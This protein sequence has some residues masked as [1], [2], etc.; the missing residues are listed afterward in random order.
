MS[1]IF[2]VLN[3]G[4]DSWDSNMPGYQGDYGGA[5]NW[6]RRNKA[7]DENDAIDARL[8]QQHAQKQEYEKSGKFWLK[9]K[10]SQR[11]LPSGPFTGKQAANTAALELLKQQPELKGNLVITAYGP[12]ETQG[13]AEA[14]ANYDA[15]WDEKVKRVGQ[16]AK[17]GP[18]KTV[19][20]PVKR[21][22][23][24]VPVNTPKKEE[25]VTE[26]SP[27]TTFNLLKGLKTW[28]VVLFNNYYAGKY[29]DYRGRYYY[30]LASSPEEARQV[31]LDNSDAILQDILSMKSQNGKKI[32][33]RGTA[34][35]ITDK[36]IGEI[37]DGT[38]AGRMSTMGFKR[39][40][41][42]QGPMMVKLSDGAVVDIQGQ[43]LGVAEG[44]QFK[45]G[46]PFDVDHMP[47]AV[48][49]NSDKATDIVKTKN[50]DKWDDEVDRIND[51]VFDDMSDFRT[52]SKGETVTGNSA[53][54]AKWDNATQTGWINR[55]GQPLKPWPV[56]EQ[57]VA[58]A[59]RNPH[60]SALGKA[61]YR[62]LSKEKKAS[63]QQVQRN[64][65]RWAQRQAEK[66]KEVDEGYDKWGWHTSLTNGKFMPTK[67]GNKMYVYLHDLDNESPR[68]GPQLVTVNKPTV[69]KR[70]AQQ[71]GGE[72]VKTD[73]NTYR[74]VKPAEQDV[75]EDWQKVNKKDK[76]D[77][78]SRKAVKAYRRENPGSKLQTAV[79]TKPSKLKKGSKSAKRRKSFCARMKGMKKAHASAKTK[80][81]PD[82]PINKALRR[83]NCESIEQMQE[84]IMIAE[85]KI[86]EAK[87]A[88]Q[89][90]A[91]A[92]AKKKAKG[93][94][95]STDVCSVCGQTPCNCTHVSGIMEGLTK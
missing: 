50:K 68:G 35:P 57:G 79:T 94:N 44:Y 46:F 2:K 25:G 1:S 54:W 33:P 38:E 16:L 82:S 88:K 86:A 40:F 10:D 26:A 45:G 30:V 60:T 81:N 24:T 15:S 18:R 56:K 80:R 67:Y 43:E 23:K 66:N 48:I 95:E 89:Q 12:D 75:T 53:V 62:D 77:G 55:K 51:E 64:K 72:V 49:R 85:A 41:G 32:L 71:F 76:T 73:L 36:R 78:M 13:V 84:L 74:I 65:E 21:V 28:Q 58:E 4:R 87:N 7:S 11:H 9:L 6:G 92:I 91:I 69:A 27:E 8:R 20:D 90:A 37:K 19:W 42:P 31:V 39:M 34:L 93:L 14:E 29:S 59:E 3:E 63:P 83:W 17:E 47:G 52:D 22:Y 5:E 70:I 61:L